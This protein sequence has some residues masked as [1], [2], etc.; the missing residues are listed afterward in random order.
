MKKFTGGGAGLMK[1]LWNSEFSTERK[2]K[3]LK[4]LKPWEHVSEHEHGFMSVAGEEEQRQKAE[5]MFPNIN[6]GRVVF[7]F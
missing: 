1:G 6:S 2:Q 5:F 3:P 7:A 4:I